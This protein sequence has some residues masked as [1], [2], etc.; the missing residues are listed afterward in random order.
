MRTLAIFSITVSAQFNYSQIVPLIGSALNTVI[1]SL[2]QPSKDVL[3]PVISGAKNVA[4]LTEFYIGAELNVSAALASNLQ[5][6]TNNYISV[7]N[8]SAESVVNTT[9]GYGEKFTNLPFD[10]FNNYVTQV[11]E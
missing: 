4:N 10:I 9:V 3:I 2:P 6:L 5:N 8:S 11:Q 7:A 1:L